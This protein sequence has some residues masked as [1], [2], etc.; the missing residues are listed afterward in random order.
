MRHSTRHRLSFLIIVA[1]F[2]LSTLVS[3][4]AFADTTV[5]LDQPVHFTTADGS[6]VVLEEGS[7][8][9]EAAENWLRVIPGEGQ[10]VDALLLEAQT[11]N[12]EE[13]LTAPLSISAQGDQPDT[14]HL[15]LLLQDGKRLEAIGSY[16][17]IRS[18]STRSVLSLHRLKTIRSTSQ[19]PTQ[20]TAPTEFATPLIGGSG[21]HTSYNLNCGSGSVL[22]GATY[23]AGMWLDAIGII[24]Q[25]VNPQTGALEG[26]FTRGPVGGSGGT[27]RIARCNPGNVVQGIR[28]YSGQ[29]VHIISMRCSRWEASRKAPVHSTSGRCIDDR[30]LSFGGSGGSPSDTFYCPSG[31]AGKAFRGKHGI[32]IDSTRF[33]CNAWDQ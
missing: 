10:T 5:T 1:L 8:S 33:V 12:H 29:F 9:L 17:G 22:V 18:R 19:S 7:Y 24:C 27:A 32:Y 26:E 25:R 14:H 31:Q 6:A 23:K 4:T 2:S 3:G 20:S 28:G 15:A 21:G 16:S 30:C 11:A 13:T